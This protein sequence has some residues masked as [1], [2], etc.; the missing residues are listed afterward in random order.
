M[1]MESHLKEPKRKMRKRA[2]FLPLQDIVKKDY[3]IDYLD[4]FFAKLYKL[5]N[6]LFLLFQAFN[7]V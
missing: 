2:D 1:K 6:H 4:I 7:F 3:A 5:K